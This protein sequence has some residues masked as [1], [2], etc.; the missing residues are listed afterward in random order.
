M[1]VLTTSVAGMKDIFGGY[2]CGQLCENSEE[3]IYQMLKHQLDN[4]ELREKYVSEC[5]KRK[6]FFSIENRMR[7]IE[8]L[9]DEA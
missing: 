4:P 3:G 2:E 8:A 5:K 1:P 6:D 9:Y 7:D